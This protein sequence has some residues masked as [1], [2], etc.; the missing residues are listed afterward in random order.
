MTIASGMG[1][2]L[3]IGLGECQ[4]ACDAGCVNCGPRR[5]CVLKSLKTG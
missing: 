4:G 3:A 2:K 1:V 5:A